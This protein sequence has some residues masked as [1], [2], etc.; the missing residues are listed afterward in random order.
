MP[1][2]TLNHKEAIR[3]HARTCDQFNAYEEYKNWWNE[4]R[5]S[6]EQE[7][8]ERLREARIYIHKRLPKTVN[9]HL[10]TLPDAEYMFIMTLI[11]TSSRMDRVSYDY[12]PELGK[13]VQLVRFNDTVKVLC[14]SLRI[15]AQNTQRQIYRLFTSVANQNSIMGNLEP[16]KSIPADCTFDDLVCAATECHLTG[17]SSLS[18][19]VEL[20]TKCGQARM[21]SNWL[22]VGRMKDA[23][24]SDFLDGHHY[25]ARSRYHDWNDLCKP[26]YE[27]S[28][29]AVQSVRSFMS[30][31]S[32][33]LLTVHDSTTDT[34]YLYGP[35]INIH[36]SDNRLHTIPDLQVFRK[37]GFEMK[38]TGYDVEMFMHHLGRTQ[39]DRSINMRPLEA[40]RKSYDYDFLKSRFLKT[41]VHLNT[42]GIRESSMENV[43]ELQKNTLHMAEYC[44]H[45]NMRKQSSSAVLHALEPDDDQESGI[46]MCIVRGA[47]RYHQSVPGELK[48]DESRSM[49]IGNGTGAGKTFNALLI[50]RTGKVA[51]RS[52]VL[53]QDKLLSH[54]TDEISK[55][56]TWKI[57]E[58]RST[59]WSDHPEVLVVRGKPDVGEAVRRILGTLEKNKT[60]LFLITH[61]GHRYMR[62]WFNEANDAVQGKA[63][64]Y[65]NRVFVEE[66]HML[67]ANLVSYHVIGSYILKGNPFV[68]AITATPEDS[69]AR[70]AKLMGYNGYYSVMLL[71][72]MHKK[73]IRAGRIKVVVD[74]V[75]CENSPEE[76]VFFS[77][78]ANQ[79]RECYEEG[80][81]STGLSQLFRIVEGVTNGGRVH[82][83]LLLNRLRKLVN[84]RKNRKRRR[85]YMECAG[86]DPPKTEMFSTKKAASRGYAAKDDMC[87]VCSVEGFDNPVQTNCGHIYCKECVEAM[88]EMNIRPCP[89]CTKIMKTFT[90]PWFSDEVR[91]VDKKKK[92]KKATTKVID[93]ITGV[94][95]ED[96]EEKKQVDPGSVYGMLNPKAGDHKGVLTMNGKT[97]AFRSRFKTWSK[98]YAPGRRAVMFVQKGLA[99]ETYTNVIREENPDITL[100]IAGLGGRDRKTS[101]DNINRFKLGETDILMLSPAYCTGFDLAEGTSEVWIMGLTLK[102]CEAVQAIG[103]VYRYSQTADAVYVRVFMNPGTFGH[104]MWENRRIGRFPLTR[105]TLLWFLIWQRAHNV[106]LPCDEEMAGYLHI[107]TL[108]RAIDSMRYIVRKVLH[109]D[110]KDCN[111]ITYQSDKV[112]VDFRLVFTVW[113]KRI[114]SHGRVAYYDNTGHIKE[115]MNMA[116]A[117]NFEDNQADDVAPKKYIDTLRTYLESSKSKVSDDMSSVFERMTSNA[118]V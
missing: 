35:T 23:S 100:S 40:V 24:K 51:T 102:V 90:S 111:F 17:G 93:L 21:N 42:L 91:V 106:P 114:S 112:I 118:I 83:E 56:T 62:T 34:M 55:H 1:F 14:K 15:F 32:T 27:M 104:F 66:A 38:V 37:A 63:T 72:R 49:L 33:R 78:V 48:A 116:N 46:T 52:A 117:N 109:K 88:F 95:A 115:H 39:S 41:K 113:N 13:H 79:V 110:F 99:Y 7:L 57:A 92:K 44:M 86:R 101:L 26:E 81:D 12:V 80:G 103:R 20:Y 9:R 10:D 50:H 45:N 105:S 19:S 31:S 74:E 60:E 18:S 6:Q 98:N 77:E 16:L 73:A 97:N 87:P 76:T 69:L 67:S 28:I 108:P 25:N 29:N 68:A 70:I 36:N 94:A 22:L 53:V 61:N 5:K 47:A 65:F 54:W 85:N 96:G 89:M 43:T 2:D 75:M 82:S 3:L 8:V 59:S 58:G 30:Q 4:E 84:D 11:F 64:R 107:N 71:Y